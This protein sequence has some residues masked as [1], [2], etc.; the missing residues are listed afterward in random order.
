MQTNPF[1]PTFGD[2][3][4]IYLD[5]SDTAFQVANQIRHATYP[6]AILITGVR[7]SGKTVML[8]RIEE[9]LQH[10]HRCHLIDLMS[11]S[12]LVDSFI[13]RLG[14]VSASSV[15]KVLKK[16][17]PA[18]IN[19]EGVGF[20][21]NKPTTTTIKDAASEMLV[22]LEKRHQFVVVCIDEVD[23]TEALRNFAKI[24]NELKRHH[25]PIHVIMTGLPDIL[26]SIQGS[27]TLTFLLRAQKEYTKA[28]NKYDMYLAYQKVFQA[29]DAVLQ[30]MVVLTKGYSYAFQLL[31]SLAF[32]Q[33]IQQK[34]PLDLPALNS[35]TLKYKQQ[36][37]ANAYNK[38]FEELSSL[39]QRYLILVGQG[40]KRQE[41]AKKLHKSANTVSQYRRRA[42]ERCLVKPSVKGAGYVTYTLPFFDEFMSEIMNPGSMYYLDIE[43]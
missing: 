3:P 33:T 27:K 7:G 9:I 10:D 23:N 13:N 18:S 42:I 8:S 16:V 43:I 26:L 20:S 12:Q 15:A 22:K 21:F 34:Q 6:N 41:I 11:D 37:F 35:I 4:K 31:G 24:F 14:D 28:L 19:I 5:N 25:L 40:L 36:L 39:D 1:N 32:K 2:V 29:D 17:A 38:I 30:Q